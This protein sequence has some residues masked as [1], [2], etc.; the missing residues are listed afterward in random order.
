[1]ENLENY[2][3]KYYENICNTQRQYIKGDISKEEL[4]SRCEIER[5]KYILHLN[6]RNL[7]LQRDIENQI[8]VT[9]MIES[10]WKK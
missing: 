4:D 2:E 7:Q 8:R 6:K 5:Q 9:A 10:I 3:L 1:M